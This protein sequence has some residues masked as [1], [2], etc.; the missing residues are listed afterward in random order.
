MGIGLKFLNPRNLRSMIQIAKISDSLDK[1]LKKRCA[2][3][4][5]DMG[6]GNEVPVVEF[7]DHLAKK[8]PD[9]ID[10]EDIEN[11]RKLIKKVVR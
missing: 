6:L 8:H 5:M 4:D 10:A 2:Y 3:C 7:V 11:Y 1:H 9:K